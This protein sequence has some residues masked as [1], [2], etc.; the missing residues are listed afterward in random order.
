MRYSPAISAALVATISTFQTTSEALATTFSKRQD[1]QVRLSS[2]VV[3]L[4]YEQYQG[5][6]NSSTGLR[7]WKGYVSLS[8]PD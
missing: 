2:L 8:S 5:V 7:E 4:G 3:D 6:V 1:F